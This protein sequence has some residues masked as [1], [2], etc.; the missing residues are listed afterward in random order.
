MIGPGEITIKT[1]KTTKDRGRFVI[2]P[3]PSGY[4]HTLGNALR[5]VLLASLPGA[6]IAEV[7]FEGVSHP[8]TTIK[9]VKE[10]V[11][12]L[13]LNLKKVRFVTH[14]DEPLEA[15]IEVKGKK[16]V[17]A[18]DI[19][20]AAGAEI[21]NP[22]LKIATLTDRSAKLS[23]RLLIEK[24]FG[25]KTSE[26]REGSKV[27][28]IPMDSIFSPVTKVTYWVEETRRGRETNLDK[29]IIEIVTDKTIKPSEALEKAAAILTTYLEPL[30]GKKPKKAKE[31]VPIEKKKE[32][33]G[34]SPEIRKIALS[35]LNLSPQTITILTGVGI[36]SVGG[37]LQKSE[38]DLLTVR[39]FGERRLTGIRRELKKL[40]IALKE[41]KPSKE[42]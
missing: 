41:V 40:G 14:V 34:P 36:K 31:A 11:I 8:F 35:D 18:G 25:Y 17:T 42:E 4:G 22:D 5:R 33:K 16:E 38:E 20:V 28:V 13:I 2:E 7:S 6:A 24:G 39:G 37:L 9:G 26:E 29:L 21:A 1:E 10:D 32:V 15:R 3:L 27:G 23:A 12:E 19:K 30:A